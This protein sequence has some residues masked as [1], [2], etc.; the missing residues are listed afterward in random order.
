MQ[1]I[2][3]ILKISKSGL[4]IICTSLVMWIALMFGFHISEKNLLDHIYAC[5][6]LLK[7][8]ENVLFL[9]QVVT[10]D[11]KWILYDNVERKRSWGRRNEPPPTTPKSGLHPKKVMFCIWWDWKRV[12]Y[13]ELLLENQTI[14]SIPVT[15]T[16]S[17]TRRKV[18]RISQ[19]KMHNLPSG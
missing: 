10:G 18:S 8:N 2:A 12:L 19:Q 4:K 16:E 3:H 7:R 15:P 11:E 6:S 1:E 17:R 14:N 13:Y 9:K 5:N